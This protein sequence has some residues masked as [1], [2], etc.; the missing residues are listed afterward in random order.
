MPPIKASAKTKI[1]MMARKKRK[2]MT[3]GLPAQ[4]RIAPSV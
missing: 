3:G 1:G 2:S 4:A